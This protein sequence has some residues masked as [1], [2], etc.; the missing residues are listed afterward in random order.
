MTL[1]L[2]STEKQALAEPS[3]TVSGRT[4]KIGS[5]TDFSGIINQINL[6]TD[7]D[8]STCMGSN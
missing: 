6:I 3:T 2:P 4:S 5:D 7:P 8:I 1:Y